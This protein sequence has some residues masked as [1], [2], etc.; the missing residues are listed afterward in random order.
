MVQFGIPRRSA[1]AN[2]NETPVNWRRGLFRV[3]VLFAVAWLM[4]WA[5]HLTMYGLQGGFKT[6]GDYL[7]IPVLLLGPPIALLLF[8]LATRWAFRGF[9]TEKVFPSDDRPPDK[10]A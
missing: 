6:I 9:V 5:I 8:G 1:N 10:V 4:G 2:S 7:V 3:W